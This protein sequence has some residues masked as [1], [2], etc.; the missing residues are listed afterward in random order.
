MQ[1]Q[2]EKSHK[3]FQLELIAGKNAAEIWGRWRVS[4][5]AATIDKTIILIK[6]QVQLDPNFLLAIPH[7]LSH[8]FS[9]EKSLILAK[10]SVSCGH[11][12]GFQKNH[13]QNRE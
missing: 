2:L 8:V 11:S 13:C 6:R 5:R 1:N 12:L 4:L 3:V 7:M 9:P 10:C